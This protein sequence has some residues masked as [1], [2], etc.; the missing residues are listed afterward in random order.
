VDEPDLK[1]RTV[2]IP[3]PLPVDLRP[4]L[5][6]VGDY[7]LLAS[8][9]TLVREIVAVK[10]GQQK[11]YKATD[12]FKRLS[13]GV[14]DQGNNFSLVAGSL[15]GAL[16]QIQEKTMAS[17]NLD[18]QVLKSLQM[19]QHGTNSGMFSVGANGP[20]GWE[21]VGNGRSQGA[22]M[23]VVPAAAVAGLLAAVAIPNFV[24]ARTVSQKNACINNLRLIDA[25]KQQWAL[26]N[27]K[28]S[29]DTPAMSDLRPY[30]GRGIQGEMP[31]C[32]NGGVYTLHSVGQ[33]PT[34]SIPGH[35][36]P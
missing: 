8:S 35:D 25:A 12:E 14:P 4:S 30:L 23:V 13:Q 18:P 29:T 32:P 34:C 20:D 31:T 5:A 2:S 10:S 24:K 21:A 6:R 3:L 26:E 15:A 28:R 7:L 22:Q 33:P 19:L 27:R 17:K 9:D 1:M 11:G 16:I 36:L